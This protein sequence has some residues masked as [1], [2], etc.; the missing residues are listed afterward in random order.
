MPTKS[1]AEVI[2][3]VLEKK[4]KNEKVK[5]L[6]KNNSFALRSILKGMYDKNIEFFFPPTEPP[7]EPSGLVDNQGVLHHEAKKLGMFVK[8]GTHPNLHYIKRENLFIQMLEQ[9]H[10]DDA[11]ILIDMIQKKGYKGLTKATINEAFPNLI[12]N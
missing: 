9:V 3:E 6:K 4:T 2:T 11:K 5:A 7:Y 10:K 8:G 1:V 12:E